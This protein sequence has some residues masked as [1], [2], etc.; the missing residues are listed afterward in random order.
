MS[1][2]GGKEIVMK[3]LLSLAFLCIVLL[4][5]S[6][7]ESYAQNTFYIS[8]TGSDSN[9]GTNALP[10]KRWAFALGRLAPGDTLIAKDGTYTRSTTGIP[11]IIC[12]SN[13]QHGTATEPITIK[14]Q[15]ERRPMLKA[16][17]TSGPTGLTWT[18]FTMQNCSWWN[19]RGLRFEGSDADNSQSQYNNFGGLLHIYQSSNI[20]LFRLFSRRNNRYANHHLILLQSSSNILL[21][22]SEVY[23]FCRH[24]ISVAGGIKITLRRNYANA[25]FYPTI[26]GQWPPD[27]PPPGPDC[28]ANGH[29]I[30]MVLYPAKQSGMENNITEHNGYGFLSIEPGDVPGAGSS[31]RFLGNMGIDNHRDVTID[32]RSAA[33]ANIVFENHVSVN[34]RTVGLWNNNNGVKGLVCKNCSFIDGSPIGGS[35]RASVLQDLGHVS[36]DTVLYRNVL[37]INYPMEGFSIPGTWSS[38]RIEYTT[39]YHNNPNFP[40]HSSCT[41]ANISAANPNFGEP[42]GDRVGIGYGHCMVYIPSGNAALKGTGKGGADRGANVIYR[43]QNGVLTGTKLWRPFS[44]AFPCGVDVLGSGHRCRNVHQRLNVG[45]NGC[46]VP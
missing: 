43:Y 46:P 3:I 17:G 42:A 40:P 13:A 25:H 24:G 16:G 11:S 10:W 20:K 45:V 8:P 32:N 1:Y 26:P 36:D 21:E 12:G 18:A 30:A 19:I 37:V 39:S 41:F 27:D 34:S 33:Q 9:P 6:I 31:N 44:G 29:S 5:F 2:P 35:P 38:C 23:D 4:F 7:V 14:A 15:N 22:E 28:T